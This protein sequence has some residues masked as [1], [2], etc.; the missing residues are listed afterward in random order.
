VK[1]HDIFCT[2]IMRPAERFFPPQSAHLHVLLNIRSH[3]ATRKLITDVVFPFPWRMND[4]HSWRSLFIVEMRGSVTCMFQI[5]CA[6]LGLRLFF[7]TALCSLCALII[8]GLYGNLSLCYVSLAAIVQ[9]TPVRIS[10]YAEETDIF[11]VP[12]N[13]TSSCSSSTKGLTPR[14][15]CLNGSIV[16][17]ERRGLPRR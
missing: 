4:P 2:T 5:A 12:L 6:L 11:T 1:L 7:Q 14:C 3:R 16:C 15:P 8:V 10:M 13:G 9:N 17:T